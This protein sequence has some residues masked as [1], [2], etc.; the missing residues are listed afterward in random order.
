MLNSEGEEESSIYSNN[1]N[2]NEEKKK[3]S[4]ENKK[5]NSHASN[6]NI[7]IKP[8]S[9][10]QNDNIKKKSSNI[11]DIF[12]DSYNIMDSKDDD[13]KTKNLDKIN[14]D[15]HINNEE[16]KQNENN[17]KEENSLNFDSIEE[18]KKNEYNNNEEENNM[19]LNNFDK[20][21]DEKIN[22]NNNY[23]NYI[24]SSDENNKNYDNNENNKN[25]I[26]NLDNN[27]NT[28]KND[29][30]I[31]DNNE[32]ENKN[33]NNIKMNISSNSISKN[34]NQDNS[35]YFDDN[36][37]CNDNKDIDN[38][39][40]NKDNNENNEKNGNN[41][42][43]KISNNNNNYKN[44]D[45]E[46]K[47][48][49]MNNNYYNKGE[50]NNDSFEL[51]LSQY[52]NNI[53]N[54]NIASI[55]N[56]SQK[57]D[58]KN[59][60]IS[61]NDMNRSNNNN[62]KKSIEN[63]N[64]FDSIN[65]MNR[66]NDN[67]SLENSNLNNSNNKI[68]ENNKNNNNNNISRDNNSLYNSNNKINENN[69]N[70]NNK[71]KK[72][73][74]INNSNNNKMNENNESNEYNEYNENQS[75]INNSLHSYYSNNNINQN[76]E[77]KPK[78]NDSLYLDNNNRESN[79]KNNSKN[80]KDLLPK[81]NSADLKQKKLPIINSNISQYSNPYIDNLNISNIRSSINSNQ[82]NNEIKQEKSNKSIMTRKSYI[83]SKSSEE[84]KDIKDE[85][86]IKYVELKRKGFHKIINKNYVSGFE[87]FNECYELSQKNLN[88]KIKQ[89]NS[90]LYMSICEYYK[91]NFNNSLSLIEQAKKIFSTVSLGKCHISVDSKNHLEIKLLTNSS[92]GNLSLNQY[93]KAISDIDKITKIINSLSEK[94]INKKI[95][96]L[97]Y[98]IYTLFKV[99]SLANISLENKSLNK[100]QK[101][102]ENLIINNFD[103]NQKMIKD[104]LLSLKNKDGNT[105]LLKSFIENSSRYKKLNDL[106]GYYF[107][108]FNKSLLSYNYL[109]NNN[110]DN[111][112]KDKINLKEMKE[113]LYQYYKCLIGKEALNK[114]ENKNKDIKQFLYEFNNKME[115][116][117]KIFNILENVENQL[118]NLMKTKHLNNSKDNIKEKNKKCQPYLIILLIQIC[119]N[120]LKNERKNDKFENENEKTENVNNINKL[121]KELERLIKKINNSEIDISSINIQKVNENIL[122]NA[123]KVFMKLSSLYDKILVHYYYIKLKKISKKNLKQKYKNALDIFLDKSYSKIVQGMELIKINNKTKGYK[124]NYYN[125]DDNNYLIIKSSKKQL[126][127]TH[128]YN[129]LKDVT[130][131]TYGIRTSNL[132]N[133]RINKNNDPDIKNF[134]KTPW[135]FMSFITNKRSIDLYLED[136]ELE[137]WFYGLN[138]LAKDN[139]VEYKLISTNKFILTKIKLKIIMKLK[140][141]KKNISEDEK[142]NTKSKCIR[143]FVKI[144]SIES[145]SFAKI[146]YFY[147]LINDDYDK[148]NKNKK[149]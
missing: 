71:S 5:K 110:K 80:S 93:D 2:M 31:I 3:A 13:D 90:L 42:S 148:I 22:Y 10:N 67:K 39:I 130:K 38:F 100:P 125:I 8:S 19:S 98:V 74:S 47:D 139:G 14:D 104:F 50:N 56:I 135:R 7:N 55:N 97:K 4:L 149:V 132:I 9:N 105:I 11:D 26:N 111:N 36:D 119:L 33:E 134:F 77:K 101:G 44:N 115:C 89:I 99:D 144:K 16:N 123:K 66:N 136:K 102:K 87:T 62:G 142:D 75:K 23:N 82:N 70:N 113:K 48:L 1:N 91:G 85:Y 20:N 143:K 138:C 122:N 30:K 64:L 76:N 65:K 41:I 40:N 146:F 15:N 58:K 51:N 107:C 79:P 53:K 128:N 12:D 114:M 35:N 86:Y 133:K 83:S 28:S 121:I 21:K 118:I 61:N 117:R 69:E 94:K 92:L 88:D 95:S 96:F 108:I 43:D 137:N 27:E 129:L 112:S 141:L 106:T 34:N 103:F 57:E 49:N 73:I 81:D 124:T 29:F 45:K 60:S 109:L 72:I 68:N 63:N 52:S 32:N 84:I 145:C 6:N 126:K 59:I 131:I 127:A 78:E 54:S 116:A 140:K 37:N 46:I 17:L 120:Y 18:N 147:H 25:E 24:N